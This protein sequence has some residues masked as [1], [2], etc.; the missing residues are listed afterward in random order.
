M[1]KKNPRIEESLNAAAK[2]VGNQARLAELLDVSSSAIWQ[3]KQS[4]VPPEHCP[5]IEKMTGIR[6]E[7]LN[8][9]VDWS[10]LRG[11]ELKK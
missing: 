11:T 4:E 7:N 10:Y 5:A 3:W 6:C 9:T 8:S 1:K 2:A